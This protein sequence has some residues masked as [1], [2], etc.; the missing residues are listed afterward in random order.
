MFRSM[1][2][3]SGCDYLSS[4]KGIG[5]KKAFVD[6]KR[7]KDISTTIRY[8]QTH[9]KL[10]VPVDY[11]TPVNRSLHCFESKIVIDPL[12]PNQ[13]PLYDDLHMDQLLFDKFNELNALNFMHGNI[14][15]R[16]GKFTQ[17]FEI[18]LTLY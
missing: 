4:I 3:F 5:I 2:N 15:P 11:E 1:Y 10:D 14:D 6:V 9:R 13:V 16:T 17:P 7:N 18:S 12:T 8:F